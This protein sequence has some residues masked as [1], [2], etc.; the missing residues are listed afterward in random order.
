MV[1]KKKVQMGHQI[2]KKYQEADCVAYITMKAKIKGS[3]SRQMG[4]QSDRMLY[5]YFIT[6]YWC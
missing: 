3:L 2:L 6:D 1:V 4:E 5:G